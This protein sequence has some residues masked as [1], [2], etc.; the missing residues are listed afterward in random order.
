MVNVTCSVAP[1][2]MRTRVRRLNIGSRTAANRVGQR[3][4]IHHRNRFPQRLSTPDKAGPVGFVLEP[5]VGSAVG[6][7]MGCPD[8][9]VAGRTLAPLRD[10]PTRL[11][12]ILGLDEQIGKSG[13]RDVRR[14]GCEYDLRIGGDFDFPGAQPIIGQTQATDFRIV[15]GRDDD[16]QGAYHSCRP[17]G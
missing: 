8:F 14:K 10:Q 9:R 16:L 7:H 15:L 12:Q 6:Q 3:A 2:A 13:M 1:A 5:V 4:A 11:G 17:C